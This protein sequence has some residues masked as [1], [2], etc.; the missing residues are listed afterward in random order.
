MKPLSVRR[1]ASCLA[2]LAFL[3][4]APLVHAQ[5]KVVEQDGSVTYTVLSVVA[6]SLLLASYVTFVELFPYA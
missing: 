4:A 6:Q 1:T 5:Y 2:S 3:A